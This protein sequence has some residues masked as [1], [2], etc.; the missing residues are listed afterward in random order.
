M[1][2]LKKVGR[3]SFVL[4]D[5]ANRLLL[6]WIKMGQLLK[7]FVRNCLIFQSNEP[8]YWILGALGWL[9]IIACGYTLFLVMS[10]LAK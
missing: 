4:F 3:F 10:I 7:L 2:G 6:D 8:T 9:S 5:N 1:P